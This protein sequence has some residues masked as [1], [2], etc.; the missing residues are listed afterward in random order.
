MRKTISIDFDGVIRIGGDNW[1]APSVVN[2]AAN[3]DALRFILAALE[4]GWDVVVHSC[5]FYD[6]GAVAA[7]REWIVQRAFDELG[8]I[9]TYQFNRLQYS[10]SK[11]RARIYI[12][13]KAFRYEPAGGFPRL[14]DIA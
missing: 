7:V 10:L 2:G 3:P 9:A 4:G 1:I 13:D 5:R 14:E 8:P 6:L 12:D 11:P